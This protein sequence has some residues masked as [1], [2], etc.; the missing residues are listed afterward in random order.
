MILGAEFLFNEQKVHS[1]SKNTLTIYD[2]KTSLHFKKTLFR[3]H[4]CTQYIIKKYFQKDT[5]IH[6]IR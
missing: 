2:K 1:I 5:I 3:Y 6:G 4:N